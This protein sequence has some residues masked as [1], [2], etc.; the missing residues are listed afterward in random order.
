MARMFYERKE[1]I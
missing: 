1:N